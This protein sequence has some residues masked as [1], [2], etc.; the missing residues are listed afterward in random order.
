MLYVKL[1][2]IKVLFTNKYCLHTHVRAH[3]YSLYILGWLGCYCCWLTMT[4]SLAHLP[5]SSRCGGRMSCGIPTDICQI[6]PNGQRQLL[7]GRPVLL[8]L[9][10]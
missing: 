1:D 5:I 10:I 6:H 9:I 8:Y 3:T 2:Q 4:M 7:T